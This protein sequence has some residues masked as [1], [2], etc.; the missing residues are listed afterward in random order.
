MRFFPRF[1]TFRTRYGPS[2]KQGDLWSTLWTCYFVSTMMSTA[3]RTALQK[4][5]SSFAVVPR[6]ISDGDP[7]FD[8]DLVDL[9]QRLR[10][11]G[12]DAILLAGGTIRQVELLLREQRTAAGQYPP[13][14]PVIYEPP[15]SPP[16]CG[17]PPSS[18]A[19]ALVVPLA[20]WQAC[21]TPDGQ[22]CVIQAR[23]GEEL[24]AALSAARNERNAESQPSLVYATDE[25]RDALL[26]MKAAEWAAGAHNRGTT[27]VAR[28]GDSSEPVEAAVPA[29]GVRNQDGFVA[30]G[31]ALCAVGDVVMVSLPLDAD[32]ATSARELRAVGCAAVVVDFELTQWPVEPEVLLATLFS[33]HSRTFGGYGLSV[34]FGSFASDQYL[35]NK[36]IKEAKSLQAKQRQNGVGDC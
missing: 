5:S 29:G 32:A 22:Q 17:L 26:G 12:A 7:T 13:P 6:L 27:R 2:V 10:L 34:G 4:P 36:K 18:L 23:T 1:D 14:C 24:R 11:A 35:I 15:Q 25:A 20:E 30:I 31:D 3:L 16:L 8:A 28:P 21:H 19:H 33:K 9:S